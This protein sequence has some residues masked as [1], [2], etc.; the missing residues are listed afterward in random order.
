MCIP[1]GNTEIF[2]AFVY[3]SPQRLS[4]DIDITEPLGF[5]NK[6]I[7]QVTWMLWNLFGIVHSLKPLR[8]E[9]LELFVSSNF[10]SLAPQRST[11]YTLDGRG[12]VLDIVV[13]QNVGLSEVIVTDIL[14]SDHDQ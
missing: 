11:Y 9:L 1:I 7:L 5:R 14:D 12:D 10:D 4:S 6:S 3:K 8:L 2:P 13:H